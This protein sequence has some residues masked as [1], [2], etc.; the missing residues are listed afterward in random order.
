FFLWPSGY[1]IRLALPAWYP[2]AANIVPH[3]VCGRRQTQTFAWAARNKR[4]R[5]KV[6]SKLLAFL[7]ALSVCSRFAKVSRFR[8]QRAV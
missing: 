8:L 3:T 4:Q 1:G 6:P 5:G 7:T 2:E